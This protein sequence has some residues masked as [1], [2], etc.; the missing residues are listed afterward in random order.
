M[1]QDIL[2]P[3]SIQTDTFVGCAV[4][5]LSVLMYALVAASLAFAVSI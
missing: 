2:I 3:A 1:W 4:L 5:L